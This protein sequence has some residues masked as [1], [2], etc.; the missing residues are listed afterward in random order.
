MSMCMRLCARLRPAKQVRSDLPV[1]HGR[2]TA[3]EGVYDRG[4]EPLRPG[5]TG[6]G[7]DPATWLQRQR[8]VTASG[9]CKIG[10]DTL[11][12]S[13]VTDPIHQHA[14]VP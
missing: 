5:Q 8:Q 9:L 12:L 7:S 11:R 10:Q 14:Q 13:C 3:P 6:V 2:R 4:I 1:I